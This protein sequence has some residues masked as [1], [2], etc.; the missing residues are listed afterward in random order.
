VDFKPIS[1]LSMTNGRVQCRN[2]VPDDWSCNVE[3]PS[4]QTGLWSKEPAYHN[5]RQSRDVIDQW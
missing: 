3:T 5:I 1:E 2:R 4:G